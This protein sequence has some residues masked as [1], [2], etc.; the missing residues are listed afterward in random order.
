MK[1]WFLVAVTAFIGVPLV[2]TV[3]SASHPTHT[4]QAMR[5]VLRQTVVAP[6]LD[7]VISPGSGDPVISQDQAVDTAWQ[8]IGNVH[9]ASVLAAYVDWNGQ[10]MWV[11]S[12]QGGD[13][14]PPVTGYP[15]LDVAGQCVGNS[16][17]VKIDA[18]TGAWLDTFAGGPATNVGSASPAPS[19]VKILSGG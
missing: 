8:Q 19:M 14:C 2:A 7:R 17:N 4:V 12:F 16:W 15:G 13:I 1:R 18:V 6:S 3:V 9:P 11:V 10:P 5:I